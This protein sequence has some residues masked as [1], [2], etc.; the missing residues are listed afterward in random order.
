MACVVYELLMKKW[1][2]TVLL[3]ENCAAADSVYKAAKSHRS[4]CEVCNDDVHL[5]LQGLERGRLSAP[6][7]HL[8]AANQRLRSRCSALRHIT[9]RSHAERSPKSGPSSNKSK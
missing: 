3:Q 5:D 9:F 4:F 8:P 6:Y 2:R 7:N 1:R